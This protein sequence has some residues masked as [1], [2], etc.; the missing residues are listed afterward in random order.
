MAEILKDVF[1]DEKGNQHY[2]ANNTETTFDQNGTP[3]NNGGDL[4]EASVNF[5]VSSSRKALT[6]KARFKALMGDIAKWLTD[7]GPAAFY[8]V[9]DDFTTTAENYLFTA[10]KGKQLKDEVD[11]L[12]Q[13][14]NGYQFDTINGVPSYKP[15]SGTDWVPFNRNRISIKAGYRMY[16]SG[17]IT[18]GGGG[19]DITINTAG[20]KKLI[21]TDLYTDHTGS[22]N[23]HTSHIRIIIGNSTDMILL[24]KTAQ[25]KEYDVSAVDTVILSS[26]TSNP[27]TNQY[28]AIIG[29][30]EVR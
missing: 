2:L 13:N 27:N 1:E 11:N 19:M 3:L 6:A 10:R 30:I 24:T 20:A 28:N 4:S 9:A 16:I 5:T 23:E 21:L 18:S 14:L 22:Q 8:K 7:L 25:K 12:N 17:G 29:G 15:S 26:F